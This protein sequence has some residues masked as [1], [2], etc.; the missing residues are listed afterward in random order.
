MGLLLLFHRVAVLLALCQ[1][2]G[3]LCCLILRLIALYLA[4]PLLALVLLEA[5]LDVTLELA[6]LLWR[7]CVNIKLECLVLVLASVLHYVD[8]PA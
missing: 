6:T 1:L 3:R 7:E 5:T 4:L 2:S 8:D